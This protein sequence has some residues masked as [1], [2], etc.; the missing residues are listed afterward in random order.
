MNTLDTTTIPAGVYYF[1]LFGT[2]SN[3]NSNTFFIIDIYKYSGGVE[4][5]ILSCNSEIITSTQPNDPSYLMLQS[6]LATSIPCLSTDKLIY[7]ISAQSDISNT[8]VNFY[9]SGSPYNS[10][11]VTPFI[12]THND[13]SNI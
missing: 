2:I 11:S 4:T 5:L 9:H 13:S 3:S 8:D 7:V 1:Y 6:T 12:T 10:Y